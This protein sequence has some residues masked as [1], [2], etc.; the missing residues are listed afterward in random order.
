MLF[1]PQDRVKSALPNSV[2]VEHSICNPLAAENFRV[3]SDDQHLLIIGS[4][5]NADPPPIR[6]VT[7]GPPEK[8]ML[9]FRRAGMSVAENLTALRIDP[10]HYVLNNASFPG[11]GRYEIQIDPIGVALLSP[12]SVGRGE[13]ACP[14]RADRH[15]EQSLPPV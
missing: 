3:H 2:L 5:E 7:G 12:Y 9:Q 6:Q 1:Q 13:I 4:V 10:R 14:P 11:K 8:I 15:P